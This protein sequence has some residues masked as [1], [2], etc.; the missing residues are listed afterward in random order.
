[1]A[2]CASELCFLHFLLADVSGSVRHVHVVPDHPTL[3]HSQPGQH[4]SGVCLS[5]AHQ[6]RKCL[7]VC[8]CIGCV[9][10]HLHHC[11]AQC[12]SYPYSTGA[13]SCTHVSH[14]TAPTVVLAA[15][16]A[17][18]AAAA[19]QLAAALPW[20]AL[21]VDCDAIVATSCRT[22]VA[23]IVACRTTIA[24]ATPR[25]TIFVLLCRVLL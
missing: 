15:A 9:C 12:C 24:G 22:T 2:V 4:P 21:G 10:L 1:M 20:L 11:W 5:L 14:I 23:A 6:G 3:V 18:I 17:A 8:C 25:M 16:A 19:D 7:P 13:A